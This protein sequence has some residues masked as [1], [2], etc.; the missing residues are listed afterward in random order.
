MD[1]YSEKKIEHTC[2]YIC[3]YRQEHY[4]FQS[5][6]KKPRKKQK[7]GKALTSAVEDDVETPLEVGEVVSESVEIE[8]I[9]DVASVHLAQH[10]LCSS[11]PENKK[12]NN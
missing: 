10:T 4:P 8:A 9:L 3:T 5:R 12:R 2:T 1:T 11:T 6:K 7:Q